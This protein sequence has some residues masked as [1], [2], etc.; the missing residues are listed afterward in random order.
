MSRP[1]IRRVIARLTDPQAALA[2]GRPVPFLPATSAARLLDLSARGRPFEALEDERALPAPWTD[3]PLEALRRYAA[4]EVPPGEDPEAF[5]ARVSALEGVE[6]AYVEPLGTPPGFWASSPD[7]ALFDHLAPAPFGVDAR[8][9][10]KMAGGA[11]QGVSLVDIEWGW[12]LDREDPSRTGAALI[13]GRNFGYRTH[14]TAVLETVGG[15]GVAPALERT[16]L[17]GQFR[18]ARTVDGGVVSDVAGAVLDAAS[19][20]SPGDVLLLEVQIDHPSGRKVPAECDPLVFEAIRAAT[21]AGVLVVEPAG[22]GDINLSALEVQGRRPLDLSAPDFRDSGAVVVAGGTAADP[23]RRAAL[24]GYGAR[25]DCYAWGEGVAALSAGRF[26]GTSAASAIVA[27]A[28]CAVQGIARQIYGQPL[29]PRVVRRLLSAP[30]LGTPPA[31]SARAL[32]GVMPDL[33]AILAELVLHRTL[34]SLLRY[35]RTL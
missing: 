18:D 29:P 27:G 12:Q 3:S 14:G 19:A 17:V 11:G 28:A 16:A 10:W 5:A 20:L 34:Q 24:S 33:R 23:H 30:S 26:Q 4:L 8:F 15:Q 6:R 25:V 13:A 32:I 2:P 21:D 31:E 1:L 22:N 35:V 7:P 9:A